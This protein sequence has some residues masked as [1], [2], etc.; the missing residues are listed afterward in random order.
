MRSSSSV[1]LPMGQST[2]GHIHRC[3]RHTT[4]LGRPF[5]DR[6]TSSTWVRSFT[7]AGTPHLGQPTDGSTVSTWIFATPPGPSSTPRN[8][9]SGSPIIQNSARRACLHGGPP[10]SVVEQPKT[11]GP[12]LRVRGSA[13]KTPLKSEVPSAI[14]RWERPLVAPLGKSTVEKHLSRLLHRGSR[15]ERTGSY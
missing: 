5:S 4:R 12:P 10:S 2:S 14:E 15:I 8:L 9:M 7:C 13:Y 6:S 3:F 11:G 1:Q